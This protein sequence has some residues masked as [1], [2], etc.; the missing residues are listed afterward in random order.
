MPSGIRESSNAVSG[1]ASESVVA[2]YGV[3][4]EGLDARVADVLKLLVVGRVHVGFMGIDACSAPADFPDF[5]EIGVGGFEF[6]AFFEWVC[7]EVSL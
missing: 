2:G 6:G 3:G 4:D 5:V 7:G 1:L